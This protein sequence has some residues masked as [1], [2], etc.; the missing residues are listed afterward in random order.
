VSITE[1]QIEN[2][3]LEYLK[4]K[5]IYA[6]KNQSVGIFDPTK[7]TF[8]RPGKHQLNGVSDIL[9]CVDGLILCIEVKKPYISKKTN[10]IK[11]RTQEELEKLA[12]D[13]QVSFIN[14]IKKLGGIAFY[15]DSIEVLEEQLILFGLIK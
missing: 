5:K 4:L 6:W 7:R 13:D 2:Y 15:A 10:L 3:I 8:R 9:G 11:H 12:S 1:K 14:N